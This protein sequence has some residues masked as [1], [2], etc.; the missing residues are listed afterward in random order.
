MVNRG[1]VADHSAESWLGAKKE[2]KNRI[3]FLLAAFPHLFTVCTY[4]IAW[5]S[6]QVTSHSEV[7]K[8]YVKTWF[9]VDLLASF[10]VDLIAWAMQG[11]GTE[12][13]RCH[14]GCSYLLG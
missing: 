13:G 2:D 1:Y 3:V 6:P 10:P 12:A 5:L 8:H 14:N 7:I 9:L 11:T 4:L